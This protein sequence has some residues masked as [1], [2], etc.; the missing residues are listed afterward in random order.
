MLDVQ[1]GADAADSLQRIGERAWVRF[2]AGAAPLVLQWADTLRRAV[3]R[4]FNPQH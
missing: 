4:R 2:D 1:L 3:E